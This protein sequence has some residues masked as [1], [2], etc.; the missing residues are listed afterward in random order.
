MHICPFSIS[1]Q[2]L[3]FISFDSCIFYPCLSLMYDIFNIIAVLLNLCFFRSFLCIRCDAWTQTEWTDTRDICSECGVLVIPSLGLTHPWCHLSAEV[4]KYWK[5]LFVKEMQYCPQCNAYV[6]TVPK[7]INHQN[8]I[9]GTV[10]NYLC[11]DC[12]VEFAS[13]TGMEFHRISAHPRK[14]TGEHATGQHVY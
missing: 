4:Q 12:D 3:P 10:Q 8:D 2:L 14:I 5:K 13:K 1:A 9:H 7:N 6:D 11:R